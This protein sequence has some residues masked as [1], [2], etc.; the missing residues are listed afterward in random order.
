LEKLV[1]L[2]LDKNIVTYQNLHFK[3]AKTMNDF[4][5]QIK[6][7]SISKNDFFKGNKNILQS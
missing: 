2:N 4:H 5:P 3:V 1:P 6:N 7:F